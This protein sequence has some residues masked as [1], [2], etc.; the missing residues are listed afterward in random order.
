MIL[1]L[2]FDI[3][4]ELY[5]RAL[6]QPIAAVRPKRFPVW[7]RNAIGAAGFVLSLYAFNMAFFSAETLPVMLAGGG[8]GAGIV[9]AIWWRQHRALVGLHG[10]Y[11]ETSGPQTMHIDQYGIIAARPNIESQIKWPFVSDVRCIDGA[12]LIELP[13]ARLIVPDAALPDDITQGEFAA[14]LQQW[15]AG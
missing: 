8:I 14:Q 4:P 15:K 3:E 5:R 1:D 7:L 2:S 11:N 10:T 12:T 6:S 13:T 9:L